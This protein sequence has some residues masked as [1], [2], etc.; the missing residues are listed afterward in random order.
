MERDANDPALDAGKRHLEPV[1]SRVGRTRLPVVSRELAGVIGVIFGLVWLSNFD[2]GRPPARMRLA[3]GDG[4]PRSMTLA[5]ALSP[6]GTTIATVHEDGRVAL[7]SGALGASL[8]RV[9]GY[10]GAAQA[11]AFSPDSQVLAIGGKATG[12]MLWGVRTAGA[13]RPLEIRIRETNALALSP[14]GRTLAATSFL[15]DEII[16][17]DVAA[18][19]E[20]ARL[21]GHASNVDSFA[22]APDGRFLASGGCSERTIFIWDLATGVPKLRLA[23][24]SGPVPALAYSPDGSLLVSASGFESSVRVWDLA[25]G[26]LKYL[27]GS[28]APGRNSVAFAPDGRLLATADNDGM[29]KLWNVASGRLLARLDGRSNRIGGVAFSPDG[30]ILAAIGNDTDVRLWD[31]TEVLGSLIDHKAY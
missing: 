25:S 21:R 11:V 23:A 28:Y 12:V 3:R 4:A 7:R 30:R 22:F 9:L 17:W 2:S 1:S 18:G 26:R 29:V 15:S 8:P 31:D 20:R 16:L 19:R 13:E 24:P 27:L 6:D 10:R 5:F 14:D